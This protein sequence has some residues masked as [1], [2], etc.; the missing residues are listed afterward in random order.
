MAHA[1]ILR[2][3]RSLPA[4]AALR[5]S[6]SVAVPALSASTPLVNPSI[7]SASSSLIPSSSSIIIQSRPFRSSP[8]IS[9]SSTPSGNKTYHLYKDGDEITP[10][11]ILFEGCDYNHWLITMEFP[12]DPKPT[13][14]EM[15]RTYEETCAKGLNISLEEAKKRIYACSTTTYQGFQAIMTEE[16]SEK[17]QGIP[18]VVF[19][20]PDS[21]I[22]P[23][24]KEYG[25]DKY[26]NGTI[27]PRP[28]PIQHHT[29]GRF[30]DRNRNY[31]RRRDVNFGAPRS[32]QGGPMQNQQAWPGNPQQNSSE[33]MQGDGRSY[34][35]HQ[36]YQ[37]QQN[38][39]PRQNYQ[40]QQNYAPPQNYPPQQK[41]PPPQNYPPQ[42]NFG[43]P[44]QGQREGPM[45]VNNRDNAAGGRDSYQAEGRGPMPSHQ[46]NYN[47]AGQGNYNLPQGDQSGYGRGSFSGASYGGSY[48]QGTS[49][50][51][52]QSYH[53]QG[54]DQRFS[55]ADQGNIQGGHQN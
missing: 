25:G 32:Q 17:F 7:S 54:E 46:G 14:E 24:N 47:Q 44:G 2:L 21:Y 3:R 38:Y 18:G 20:L 10:D 16:E 11:T 50:S 12:K 30:R 4:V 6:L 26:I 23:Q 39:P 31:D 1:A 53:G 51:Y 5:R 22:D 52:G 45:L 48:G 37:P 43:P 29:G 15:V 36:N 33:P 9:L 40:P 34:G 28:P 27:I 49:S 55:Q 41:Y 42:Q 35:A 8:T 13:P 19:I